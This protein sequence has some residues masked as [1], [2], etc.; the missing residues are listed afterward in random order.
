MR[1]TRV[2]LVVLMIL[3]AVYSVAQSDLSQRLPRQTIE[4]RVFREYARVERTDGTYRRMLID[5]ISLERFA[6][7]NAFPNGA[8][9][10]METYYQP[11]QE[12]TNFIKTRR[13]ER[14]LY[15]S[16]SP[17]RPNFAVRPDSSCQ[18]CHNTA[19]REVAGTFTRPMLET[20]LRTGRVIIT[21]CNRGGRT[22]CEA[23]VYK[24]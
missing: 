10:V 5:Q 16:F 20:A 24:E 21:T 11:N 13:G 6:K 3:S 12:S 7:N 19:S 14:W 15:G 9:I 4:N 8:T 22:P 2:L 18:G 1:G 23:S 17:E